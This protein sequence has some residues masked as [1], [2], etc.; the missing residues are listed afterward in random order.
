MKIKVIFIY[1]Y[2]IVCLSATEII[3]YT[4]QFKNIGAGTAKMET[5]HLDESNQIKINFSF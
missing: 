1:T 5:I 4:A 3:F 2:S